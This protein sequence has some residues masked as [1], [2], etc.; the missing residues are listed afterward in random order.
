MLD[1]RQQEQL[2]A[3]VQAL[4]DDVDLETARLDADHTLEVVLCRDALCFR[5]YRITTDEVNIP[6]ALAGQPEAQQA[7]LQHLRTFLEGID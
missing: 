2:T 1:A 7:L 3:I 6:A 4:G 5:P